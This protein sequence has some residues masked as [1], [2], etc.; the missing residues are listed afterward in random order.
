MKS[1]RI[2]LAGPGFVGKTTFLK[3]LKSGKYDPD[4]AF[5]IG[6]EE[7]NI[8]YEYKGKNFLFK[9]IDISGQPQFEFDRKGYYKGSD[10]AIL[11][12]SLRSP[13]S[14]KEVGGFFNEII[15]VCGKIPMIIAG[16]KADLWEKEDFPE[17]IIKEKIEKIKKKIPYCLFSSKNGKNIGK[18]F[19]KLV[20]VI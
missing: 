2:I 16:A 11:V 20:E 1:L 9:I 3:R 19:E 14:L 5:T 10:A 18:V 17:S 4:T 6:F 7:S 8:K 15:D 12:F 13:R